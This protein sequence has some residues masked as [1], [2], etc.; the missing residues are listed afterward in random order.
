MIIRSSPTVGLLSKNINDLIVK[1]S[2][3]YL[4]N[5]YLSQLINIIF[6]FLFLAISFSAEFFLFKTKINGFTSKVTPVKTI[7]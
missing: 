4:L 5:H 7:L 2:I 1:N 6:V 3:E